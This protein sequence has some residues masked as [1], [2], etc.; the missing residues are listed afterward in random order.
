MSA[1]AQSLG[2]SS[3]AFPGALTGSW[4]GSGAIGIARTFITDADVEDG[5]LTGSTTMPAL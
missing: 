3:I 4:V 5:G 1:R 2:P